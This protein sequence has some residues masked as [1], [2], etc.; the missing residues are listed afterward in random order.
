MYHGDIP[1]GQ[2]IDIKFT[3]R[4]FATGVPTSLGG[5]PVV[6]AYVG[7]NT[8]QITAGITLTPDFDSVT[9]LNHVR[10][11]VTGGNGFAAGTDVDLIITTGTVGGTSVVGEKVAAFS[12]EN[13][14]A[15]RPAT[16][17]RPLVVDANGL[18]DAT[19]VKAGPT[20]AATALTARDI[21]ASVLLSSGT[22]AGQLDF[23]AGIAKSNLT[24]ILGTALTETAG[25]IAAAF[26]KFFNIATPAATMDH[27]ILIDTATTLIN[28]PNDSAGTTTLLT[29]LSGARAGY[30]DNLNV[31]GAVAAS[32]EVTGL[33]IN[34]RANLLVPDQIE[35]PDSGTQVYKV[36]LHLFDPVGNME[37]PDSTPTIALTNAA[38]VDRSARLSAASNP[39]SG[40]YTWDYTATAGD[41]EEQ[42]VWLFS[43][44]E[45]GVT[46]TYPANS[47]V[48][49][50]TLTRFT[51]SDRSNLNAVKTK[52]D[53]LAF[54]NTN[55]VDAAFNAA[56]DLPQ[57]CADKVWA[58]ST[59][60]L[61]GFGS[62][63]ADTAT[64]IWAAATRTLT[65][66][67]NIVL[68]KGVGVTGFNDLDA[69]GVRTAVGL[70]AANLDTTL[71]QL[72]LVK[73]KTDN[74]PPDPADASDILGATNAIMA[75][76]G[77]PAGASH[78]ADVAA[79]KTD[80]ASIKLKTDDMRFTVPLMLDANIQYVNNVEVIGD[81]HTG[82]EWG[83][84]P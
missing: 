52:T 79:V 69:A 84:A 45:G 80:S 55:K 4:A 11:V 16:A 66:G 15:L 27:L 78:A 22:G 3:S 74:L 56:G 38:G 59:R 39:S 34:T 18:A 43:V 32:A 2:T 19:M 60:T 61:T 53:Q 31:G 25:Q 44:V 83:P 82:T 20:G 12:I 51:T 7:N 54:T 77:A 62:L 14:S 64:A 71:A 49:E 29:R 13:R 50:Q 48:V 76:L 1:L 68:A 40:V 65:A 21:G 57:A 8:T 70:A 23:T 10:V 47:Y 26:K 33:N 46:R 35:T 37:A 42:L 63:V 75:R 6:S 67:T 73:A 72:A 41:T 36:R 17:G 5:L 30:L 58:S 9:G 24:Q 28:A 81:G